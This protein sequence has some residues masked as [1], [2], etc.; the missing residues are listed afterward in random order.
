MAFT[1]A[2]MSMVLCHGLI[3]AM[4]PFHAFMNARAENS[5]PLRYR[6]K[7]AGKA[8]NLPVSAALLLAQFFVEGM[9]CFFQRIAEINLDP[10]RVPYPT[11]FADKGPSAKKMRLHVE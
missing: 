3:G 5:A 9:S 2:L 10:A 8:S 7:E 11:P 1:H 6:N 4:K